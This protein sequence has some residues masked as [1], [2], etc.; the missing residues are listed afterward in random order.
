MSNPKHEEHMWTVTCPECGATRQEFMWSG[1][2]DL[3]CV[4]CRERAKEVAE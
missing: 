2:P 1:E 3:R 4:A